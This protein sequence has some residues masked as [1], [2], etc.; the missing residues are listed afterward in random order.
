[1]PSISIHE[2]VGYY[3]ADKIHISSPYYYYLGI[4][5]PDAP[6]YY[7]FAS[8]EDRWYAHQRRKDLEEW[9]ES[10]LSFYEKEKNHYP[11]DFI[12][13]Y[14]IHVLTDIVYDD[15]LYLKVR[16]VIEKKYSREESHKIMREDMECFTF[17]NQDEVNHFL[18]G[19]KESFSILNISST[20]LGKWKEKQISRKEKT[21]NSQYIT[22]DII[23]QLNQIV[24]DELLHFDL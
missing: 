7:G 20:L 6:N 18:E 8:M 22:E 23:F 13:G 14:F 15:F 17:Q 11:R 1:M 21:R 19:Q 5:A 16:E 24:Y 9:R 4:I 10:I 3:L 2:E 12:L